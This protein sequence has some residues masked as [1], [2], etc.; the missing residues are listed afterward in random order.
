MFKFINLITYLFTHIC[1]YITFGWK[2]T[3]KYNF[4]CMDKFIYVYTYIYA[5]FKYVL[6]IYLYI[7]IYVY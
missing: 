2:T 4:L 6:L 5:I 3:S 7:Y 1:I